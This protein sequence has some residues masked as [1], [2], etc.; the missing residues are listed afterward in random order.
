[1]ENNAG[2]SRVLLLPSGS[3]YS[4]TSHTATVMTKMGTC[5]VSYE[6]CETE[7]YGPN[8]SNPIYLGCGTNL[9]PRGHEAWAHTSTF[10][11]VGMMGL[12]R[13]LH[14]SASVSAARVPV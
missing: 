7:R 8:V 14:S 6:A 1:M 13:K 5:T 4:Q 11:G 3:S 12:V 2:V 10:C 9:T